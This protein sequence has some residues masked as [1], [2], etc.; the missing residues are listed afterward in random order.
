MKKIF[1]TGADGYVGSYLVPELL[2]EYYHFKLLI[3]SNNP[4]KFLDSD[5]INILHGDLRDRDFIIKSVRGCDVIIHLGAIVGSYDLT[6]NMEINYEGTKNLI[7]ACNLHN[8]R[9][10]IF[11]SSVSAVRR[12]Q[13]PYGQSKK[14]AEKS[15]IESGLDYTIL[16][17]TTIMGR[18]SLG[19]N[20]I[21]QNVNRFKYFIPMVGFG[22]NT[23]HPVYIKDFTK[24][25]KKSIENDITYKKLYEV[26]GD[27]VILFRE[28]VT[29][30]NQ[31]LGNRN[32]IIIPIS[33]YFVWFI[34]V[35]LE[36]IYSTPPFTTEH[37]NALGEH[38]SMDI[39]K[40]K[41]DLDFK[42]IQL[43]QMLDIIIKR[44]LKDPP[45]LL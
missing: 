40:I 14:L 29:L 42:P 13:G 24:I 8:I 21:I 45:Q 26:G 11:I 27:Q 41:K 38:T 9:R 16:R 20:R 39:S 7:E 37:V 31:K 19:L 36:R 5:K 44:I 17:P 35:F 32:K 3:F 12:A 18:E 34:A 43:D 30:I 4:H 33:K 22:Y 2:N 15:V 10:F 23:R 6:K 1:I 28:L 25:I